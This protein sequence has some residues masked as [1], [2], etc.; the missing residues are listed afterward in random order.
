MTTISRDDALILD[1]ILRRVG[2]DLGQPPGF[3]PRWRHVLA[4][5]GEQAGL[6][7]VAQV[8]DYDGSASRPAQDLSVH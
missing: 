7:D 3:G 6:G 5:L 8:E 4:D 1:A 2:L